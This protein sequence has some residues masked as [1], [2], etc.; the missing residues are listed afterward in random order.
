[1]KTSPNQSQTGWAQSCCSQLLCSLGGGWVCEVSV[2]CMHLFW[3]S[4]ALIVNPHVHHMEQLKHKHCH[5]R[6]QVVTFV[7]YEFSTLIFIFL[8]IQHTKLC[9]QN[10]HLI[11]MNFTS[12]LPWWHPL[13]TVSTF[14]L[15]AVTQS[16]AWLFPVPWKKKQIIRL[17]TLR[18]LM[19]EW[20][21]C[22][23]WYIVFI[24]GFCFC[25]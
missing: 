3:L 16:L 10:V 19:T 23:F 13:H 17:V 4:I 11:N 7:Y 25:M 6:P 2:A 5:C 9:N 21:P 1:M 22:N 8:W 15:G 20:T 12:D 18:Q 24:M 14:L